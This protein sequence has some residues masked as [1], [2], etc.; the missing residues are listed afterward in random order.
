MARPTLPLLLLLPLGACEPSWVRPGATLDDA[1]R[2]YGL[3]LRLARAEIPPRYERRQ[4]SPERVVTERQC[5]MR[6]GRELC[7]Y[8]VI[9]RE[10]ARF[11]DIDVNSAARTD[12]ARACMQA[13]GYR[14]DGV[15]FRP[16]PPSYV[17]QH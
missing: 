2:D 15:T 14:M 3:C 1:D 17:T 9:R 5:R 12:R 11:D 7:H 10:P 8:P 13:Q 6:N 4:T 16:L